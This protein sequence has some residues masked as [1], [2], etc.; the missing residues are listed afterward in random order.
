MAISNEVGL[1]ELQTLNYIFQKNSLQIIHLNGLTEDHFNSYK[2]Q[3]D[4][5]IVNDDLEAA[6]AELSN[7]IDG[8]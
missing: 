2:D 8:E 4:H 3:Y 5:V 7:I 6:I 1:A